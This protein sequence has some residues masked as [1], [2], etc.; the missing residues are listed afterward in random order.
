MLATVAL[1]SIV[2]ALVLQ[3][4]PPPPPPDLLTPQPSP[5]AAASASPSPSPAPPFS[6]TPAAVNLHPAQS[7]TLTITSG[8]GPYTLS[9]DTP[10]VTATI[11][12][13]ART[14][15]VTAAQ[16]TGRAMLNVNDS[17]GAAVQIPVRVALDA[18]TVPPSLTLRVTGTQIDQRWLTALIQRVLQRSMQLQPGAAADVLFFTLPPSLGPGAS[19]AIPVPVHIAGGDQYFDVDATATVDLQNVAVD[20]FSPPLLM[21]D[22][23]PE[24]L[25]AAGVLFRGQVNPDAPTRLYYYHENGTDQ[26]ELAVVLSSSAPSTVQLIDASA[27][28]NIDVMSVGHAVSRDFLTEKQFDEGVVV[29]VG[30]GTPYVADQFLM[31]RLDGAAGSIGIRVLSGAPLTV[32]VVAAPPGG[33]APAQLPSALALPQLPDDGHH[34]T[35]MFSLVSFATDTIAYTAPGPDASIQYGA[36][37]PPAAAASPDIPTGHD[38]GEYGVLRTMNFD[39][40]NPL[41]EPQTLYL[42]ERPMGGVVRS[43][44]LVNGSLVQVGC[45]RVSER[46]QI[47]D[48]ITVQPHAKLVVPVQT[49]TDGGSNYPLEVGLSAAAPQPSA[50][51]ITAPDGC[52]PKPQPAVSPA[53]ASSA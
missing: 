41:D 27:G 5:S 35:G 4:T 33:L 15:T 2:L 51:P 6:V 38:Y 17:S 16:Q 29:D 13:T 23:D 19:A 3:V 45:A 44:F 39:I 28:P 10:I 48:P 18:G 24:K 43:S 42:Y 22:D 26:R 31:N 40:D 30:P 34:R 46:Y 7:Q 32:T 49:M 25:N 9:V 20:P 36:H 1:F 50:P 37:T 47:G 53:P 12:Q 8:T 11:D 52:F 21:Y 14:I